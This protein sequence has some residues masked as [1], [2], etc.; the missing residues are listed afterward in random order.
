MKDR[1]IAL[2]GA[3]AALYIFVTIFIL[4][5][6]SQVAETSRATTEDK[7]A[8]GL[9]SLYTW[10]EQSDVP[11][12]RLRRR[13]DGLGGIETLSKSGNLMVVTLPQ[14]T[15]A[16]DKEL[17]QLRDWVG[18]GN[19]L[20]ILMAMNDFSVDR[21]SYANQYS[22]NYFLRRFG[23]RMHALPIP[24]DEKIQNRINIQN[25]KSGVNK[26]K[27][28]VVTLLPVGNTAMTAGIK[29]IYTKA[30]LIFNPVYKLTSV[31]FNRASLTLL[32]SKDRG[33][34]A[35]WEIRYKRSRLWVSRFA[36]LFS[37]GQLAHADNAR[38][39]A[40]IVSNSLSGGGKVIFDDMHQGSTELYDEKAF[41]HDSRLH[42]SAWFVFAFWLLYIVGHTNRIA[43]I[44][45]PGVTA[46]AADFVQATA[47]LFAR[48]LSRVASA[49]LLYNHFFD[50][51]R[52]KYGMPTNGQP[53]WQLLERTERIDKDD[54]AMLKL[55]FAKVQS[56]RKVNLVK[57]V[58]R[59]QK[60]RSTL[61]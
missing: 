32:E 47:N 17:D 51:I 53:V 39:V 7:D 29:R 1:V 25:K 48:R 23:F 14:I 18:R 2:L 34:S 35:L 5:P 46:K 38:L 30:P 42:N 10:L 26:R 11:V 6:G 15:P 50:W 21:M 20:L 24:K 4:P 8:I 16:R 52:L 43:P 22:A 44:P 54:I 60:I 31:P 9:K 41:F 27:D 19:N 59:M 28:R 40:N 58:N 49:R 33:D 56:N 36:Y 12:Y 13:Y 61:S 57:V 37:N 45:P 55:N 3:L